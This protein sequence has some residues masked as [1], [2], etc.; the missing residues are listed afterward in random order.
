VAVAL[1]AGAALGYALLRFGSL[2]DA[3]LHAA[4]TSVVLDRDTV[5]LPA[6]R[7]GD[8]IEAEVRI[9]NLAD[10]PVRVL[11]A[12]V[13]CDCVRTAG[14]P[15]TVPPS[16]SVALRSRV[17]LDGRFH[18]P[19]EQTVTY[20]TDHPS[21]PS[22][23]VRLAGVVEDGPPKGGGPERWPSPPPREH[24]PS[25]QTEKPRAAS[26]EESR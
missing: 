26:G 5:G 2:R 23:R 4:G 3:W 24:L 12:T 18:G 25:H 22:L 19:F 17:R 10:A 13:S 11:G 21:A 16:G 9:R 15:L 20:F 8:Q 14:L 1:V 7:V 6:G